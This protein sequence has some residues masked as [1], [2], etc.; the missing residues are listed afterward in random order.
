[1]NAAPVAATAFGLVSVMVR[2]EVSL[3]PIDAAA[4]AFATESAAFT[5]SEAFA[6]AVLAPALAEVSAPAAIE[7][8]YV[9]GVALVTLTVTVHE[10]PAGM[11]PPES[12]T[13]VP[14]LAPPSPCPR[15]RWSRPPASRCSRGRPDTC[16]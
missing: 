1:M 8:L 15:R 5:V 12:A 6:A 10:P 2:T 11:V 7:L 9:P 14:P 3:V 13:L 16:R 4:N